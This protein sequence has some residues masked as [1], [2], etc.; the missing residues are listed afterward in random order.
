MC[1]CVKFTMY[2]TIGVTLHYTDMQRQAQITVGIDDDC[3]E[4]S[5]LC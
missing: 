3:G 4:T 5:M 2:D 1:V